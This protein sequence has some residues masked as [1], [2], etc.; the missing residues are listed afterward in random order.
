MGSKGRNMGQKILAIIVILAMLLM[1]GIPPTVIF[2]FATVVYF[3]WRAVDRSEQHET[4]RI[5]DFYL[6]ANE[7]LRD[8][9]RRWYGYEIGEVISQGD[10]VLHTMKDPPP[11]VYFA[12]GALHHRVH[13]YESAVEHL[14]YVVEND[15]GNEHSRYAPSP[16]LRRYVNVLRRLEREPAEGPQTMAAIR[17]LERSRRA[18][19]ASLLTESRE[20]LSEM[21]QVKPIPPAINQRPTPAHDPPLR[22]ANSNTVMPQLVAPPTAPQPIADVLRDLYDEEKK[23]A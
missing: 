5:F 9:E 16:E 7:I 18:R 22:A 13:E 6:A 19:A 11:L 1:M 10:A 17:S 8:E 23:T 12:L 3:V 4:R 15:A 2:F 20:H 21:K 14:S